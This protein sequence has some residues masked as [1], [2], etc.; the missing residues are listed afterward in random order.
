MFWKTR[1]PEHG[2][3]G[4]E[5]IV[6]T[7]LRTTVTASSAGGAVNFAAGTKYAWVDL[8]AY[9]TNPPQIGGLYCPSVAEGRLTLT[10]STPVTTSDVTGATTIYYTPYM[11]RNFAL[12]ASNG[13]GFYTFS[14]TSLALGTLTSG[15][16]YDVFGYM[17]GSTFTLGLGAA[18]TDD[19]TRATGITFEPLY[20]F[21]HQAGNSNVRYLGTI[22]TTSTTTTE[23]SAAKRFVWNAYNRVQRPLLKLEATASWNYTT[24]TWRAWNNSTANRVEVLAG[25]NEEPVQI[26][27]V[28]GANS[29]A[30]ATAYVGVAKDS[31]TTPGWGTA[32]GGGGF[33]YYVG[34]AVPVD[35]LPGLGYHYFQAME[36]GGTSVAIW[37]TSFLIAPGLSGYVMA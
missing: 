25:L 21:Y 18:W 34:A 17:V 4:S 26:N 33:G 11:G 9:A 5:R 14:E 37:G 24:A 8:T 6:A 22:R 28:S 2:K 27:F 23:D 35:T 36:Y 16:N 10:S 29:S 13:L 12:A 15:K 31:T 19:T 20:G 30:G 32:I 7:P 3:R 1:L